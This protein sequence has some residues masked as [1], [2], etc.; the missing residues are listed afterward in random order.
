MLQALCGCT[1]S[2]LAGRTRGP[3]APPRFPP[4]RRLPAQPLW[5][6]NCSDLRPCPQ[7]ALST[8]T[9]ALSALT[10]ALSP[11][12]PP[13]RAADGSGIRPPAP[14][15][16]G[17]ATVTSGPGPGPRAPAPRPGPALTP[18]AALQSQA[19][20][21][22][23]AEP[24]H[25]PSGA[26]R[27]L[28]GPRR[29]R[30]RADLRGADTFAFTRGG[31]GRGD[32]PGAGR[33]PSG[34]RP[35]PAHLGGPVSPRPGARAARGAEG[36]PRASA[37]GGATSLATVRGAPGKPGRGPWEASP[38]LHSARRERRSRRL[39]TYPRRGALFRSGHALPAP[40]SLPLRLPF[41]DLLPYLSLYPQ[42]T[43]L[44]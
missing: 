13:E 39:P 1:T 38:S 24:V 35:T 19:G 28:P 12:S 32:L 14:P 11:S 42:G 40:P 31:V 15:F 26:R 4:P 23:A 36:A 9:C 10:C 8:P 3:G 18:A 43:F 6:G 29:P 44:P 7:R 17:P 33:A 20:S 16:P 25:G 30:P 37:G 41:P 22:A 2:F 27:P 21:E 5:P 34:L